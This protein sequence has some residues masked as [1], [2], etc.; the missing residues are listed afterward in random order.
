MIS[1]RKAKHLFTKFLRPTFFIE[2]VRKASGRGPYGKRPERGLNVLCMF[3]VLCIFY[4]C[5]FNVL[6]M[7]AFKVNQRDAILTSN[8]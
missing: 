4:V 1:S 7:N 3:N 5:M 8:E 2:H 6:C